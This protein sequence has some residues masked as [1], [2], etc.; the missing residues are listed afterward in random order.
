MMIRLSSRDDNNDDDDD[1]QGRIK[2]SGAHA[3]FIG[4]LFSPSHF[5]SF[6]ENS[7]TA[8]KISHFVN[9]IF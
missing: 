3:K 9:K 5:T 4:G 6:K 1:N 2:P 8:K 7:L